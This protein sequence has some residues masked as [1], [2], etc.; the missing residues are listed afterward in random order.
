MTEWRPEGWEETKF[1]NLFQIMPRDGTYPHPRDVY[2]IAADA[3]LAALR[4]NQV[5]YVNED[6]ILNVANVTMAGSESS[7]TGVVVFIPSGKDEQS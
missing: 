3:L 1:K 5:C 2:E 6:N 4:K 7:S